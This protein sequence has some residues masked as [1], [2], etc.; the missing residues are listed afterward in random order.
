VPGSIVQTKLYVPRRR[1]ATVPRLRLSDRLSRGI[2]ARLMLVSAPAGFGK[3]T[4]L[5]AW[6][7]SAAQHDRLTAW[8]SLDHSDN[9]ATA[10]W[11][12]VIAAVQTV[13]PG[14]GTGSLA[15]IEAAQTPIEVVLGAILNELNAVPN[16]LVL[17]LDDYHVIDDRQVHDGMVFF[18]DRL[19]SHVHLVIASRADPPLPLARL[20]ARGELVEIRAA[21]LRFTPD[22]TAAY[23]NDVMTLDLAA[24]ELAILAGR[25]EGWIAALQ[26]AA[27][28]MQGRDNVAE[29]LFRREAVGGGVLTWLGCH[30]L[31]AL[32]FVTGQEIVRVQAELAVTSGEAIDVED[33]AAVSFRTAGGA[34]GSMHAGYLL[35]VGNPGYRAAGHDI[36]M[37]LR[38]TQGAIYHAGGRQ[39]AP[40]LLESVA[41]GWSGAPR[42]TQQFTQDPTPGYGGRPGLDFFRAFL[43]ARPGEATPAD[44]LDA[45]RLLEV[46]DAIYAAAASGCAVEVKRRASG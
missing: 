46:L 18:L 12:Y 31:D 16:D 36:A 5:A 9:D 15:L 7:A 10:F 26:L 41:P 1:G 21:D 34:V 38:G 17:V 32:R 33:T 20:R 28:S 14:V 25:T 40:L 43:T 22:E 6:L 11:T 24:G 27:L 30:W 3:T 35:A 39:E 29:W 19:P 23:F 45:L 37:I 4:L 13:A 44:A 42:R 8:L 2:D